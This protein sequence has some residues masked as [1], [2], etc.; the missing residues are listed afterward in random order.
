MRFA[1]PDNQVQGLPV[2][3]SCVQLSRITS[4][5]TP[6]AIV[7]LPRL[8]RWSLVRESQIASVGEVS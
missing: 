1:R 5:T 4:S 2:R 8:G 7:L 6:D 3:R